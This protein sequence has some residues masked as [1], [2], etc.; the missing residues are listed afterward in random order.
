MQ[1]RLKDL[2]ALESIIHSFDKNMRSV[3][4]V[5]SHVLWKTET[6]MGEDRRYKKQCI[7]DNGTSVPFK[8]G[9][10]GPHTVFPITISCPIVFSWI[11]LMV[12]NLF[13]FIGDFSCGK[14]QKSQ[15]QIWVIGGWVTWVI[16]CLAKKLC[17]RG[18]TGMG[19]LS[20]WSCQSSVAHSWAIFII[21]HLSTDEEHWG[22]TPY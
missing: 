16:W 13:P 2:H 19:V 3:Q 9:T 15:C 17:E 18:D 10:L 7:Q 14:S 20:L 1:G 6:S 12:W 4:K 5:S 21:L 11:S 8:V 22:S